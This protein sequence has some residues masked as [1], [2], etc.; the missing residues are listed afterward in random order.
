MLIILKK[1]PVFLLVPPGSSPAYSRINI[2]APASPT[3][4]H[5]SAM[6]MEL[7]EGSETSAYINQ[8]PG[9]Y[10]KGNLLYSKKSSETRILFLYQ[11]Q[12]V[13]ALANHS[14]FF[15]RYSLWEPFYKETD[16]DNAKCT[17]DGFVAVVHSS[18]GYSNLFNG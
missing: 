3:T 16:I 6:K 13:R 2:T 9:N 11:A 12:R 1:L 17:T 14:V 8:T 5:T 15:F 18:V 7:I 4:L 10:P